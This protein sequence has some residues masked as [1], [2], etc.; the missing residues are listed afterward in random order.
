M[1][2]YLNRYQMLR[3]GPEI[4]IDQTLF[5]NQW[6]CVWEVLFEKLQQFGS[7]PKYFEI[8]KWHE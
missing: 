7:R 8:F 2:T 6:Y 3:N 1:L 5:A 4:I